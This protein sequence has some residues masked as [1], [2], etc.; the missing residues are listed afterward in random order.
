ML[1]D[2]RTLV[3]LLVPKRHDKSATLFTM[4]WTL[5][6]DGSPDLHRV[7]RNALGA[8]NEYSCATRNWQEDMGLC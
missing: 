8:R 7:K 5:W 3:A 4:P 2:G 6:V 1:D